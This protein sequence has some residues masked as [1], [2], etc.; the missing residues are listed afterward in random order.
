M[1]T[2]II[3]HS[4]TDGICAGAIA[5]SRFPNAEV[6]FSKPAA[7]I[8]EID[9]VNAD[10]LVICDIAVNKPDAVRLAEKLSQKNEVLYFDHHPVPPGFRKALKGVKFYH[11]IKASASEIIY[12][13]FKDDIPMERVWPAI[14]GAIADY[15]DD[16]PFIVEKLKNWD[17]RAIY[18]EVSTIVMGIKNEGFSDYDAKRK[19]VRELSRGTNP[20]SFPGLVESARLA[21]ER[22]FDLY[23]EVKKNAK[24]FGKV[25]YI[26]KLS[27]FGFRGPAALFAATVTDKPLGISAFEKKRKY[28]DI[29]IR[30]RDPSLKLNI[31][32]EK[33]AQAAGGSG[34]GHPNAAGARI[35]LA[36]LKTFLKKVDSMIQNQC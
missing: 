16:T 1:K 28:F 13:T 7:L 8:R 26:V 5:L 14:Y 15:S 33:A 3:T 18:F 32:A 2:L 22:E 9:E 10:R 24:S 6:F 4:D 29:T 27:R 17:R 23:E 36:N 30:S 12:R 21:V 19:L 31:I 20:T 35:P 25:G 34:G 11:D